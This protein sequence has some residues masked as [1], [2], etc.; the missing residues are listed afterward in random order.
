MVLQIPYVD[1][2]AAK[3]FSQVMMTLGVYQFERIGSGGFQ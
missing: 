2:S 1:N 3:T